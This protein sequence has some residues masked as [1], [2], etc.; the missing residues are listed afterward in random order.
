MYLKVVVVVLGAFVVQLVFIISKF[1]RKRIVGF[2]LP[3]FL[4]HW[5]CVSIVVRG[6]VGLSIWVILSFMCIGLR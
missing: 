5:C 6:V 3:M 1:V 4:E 2:F